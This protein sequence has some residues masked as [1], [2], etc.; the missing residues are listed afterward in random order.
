MKRITFLLLLL[1]VAAIG[2]Q[3][4]TW[5]KNKKAVIVLT[6]DDALA[7]QL[8]VAIPQLDAAH[9][10]ATFFL[11]GYI[12]DKTIPR[13]RAAG[14]KGYELA[15]HTLYHPCLG[16]EIKGSSPENLSENYTI[17]AIIREIRMMNNFLF[18]VGGKVNRTYAYP[19]T[20]TKV[21]GVS[22]VDS[23]R[24]TGLIQY[25]RIGG[26]DRD[27]VTDFTK[28]D[29]LL[30]PSWGVAENTPGTKLVDF[31]KKVEKSGG[32][33]IFMFHGIGG[34]YLTTSAEAHKE[35]V[36]Y[37]QQHRDEILVMTFE[38]AMDY[39][40]QANKMIAATNKGR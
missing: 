6:Y 30:V 23:L 10:K 31:V 14:A 25:A 20:E 5:P 4:I 34:D 35:L 28:L 39:V 21:G 13:W 27:M 37:L 40:T 22:Y 8:D 38:Q 15:N 18:A 19:C 12:T 26:D 3:K 2:Q 36:T 11:T 1:T 9:L 7:S 33:G 24:K 16:K 29:P 32:M 17:P